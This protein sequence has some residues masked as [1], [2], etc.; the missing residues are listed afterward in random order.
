MVTYKYVN[1]IHTISYQNLVINICHKQKHI[2][3]KY[4]KFIQYMY[5]K[6]QSNYV[7]DMENAMNCTIVHHDKFI[8]NFLLLNS[9]VMFHIHRLLNKQFLQSSN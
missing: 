3:E 5:R 9:C 1:S 2:K 7:K 8:P 6:I 4:L